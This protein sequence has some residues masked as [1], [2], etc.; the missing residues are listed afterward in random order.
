LK[1]LSVNT[2][3]E[4][5]RIWIDACRYGI[6]NEDDIRD[7]VDQSAD[8]LCMFASVFMEISE[9]CKPEAEVHRAIAATLMYQ[10]EAQADCAQALLNDAAPKASR[11]SIDSIPLPEDLQNKCYTDNVVAFSLFGD[12]RMQ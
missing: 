9:I 8:I 2:V 1:Y 10:A 5:G 3:E 7:I 6:H 12:Q 4:V 11:S